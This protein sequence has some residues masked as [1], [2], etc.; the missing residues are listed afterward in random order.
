MSIHTIFVVYLGQIFHCK[1]IFILQFITLNFPNKSKN[2]CNF[3]K[4]IIQ[5]YVWIYIVVGRYDNR[6]LMMYLWWFNAN[7]VSKT[8]SVNLSFLRWFGLINDAYVHCYA[9]WWDHGLHVQSEV[10]FPVLWA[11]LSIYIVNR[12]RCKLFVGFL[13]EVSDFLNLRVQ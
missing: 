13:L 12:S 2:I 10:N 5:A 8:I 3:L 6:I 11:Q 9:H 4:K 1:T 7:D